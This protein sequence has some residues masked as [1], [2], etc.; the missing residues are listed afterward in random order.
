MLYIESVRL[1]EGPQPRIVVR[2]DWSPGVSTPPTCEI[3]QGEGVSGDGSSGGSSDDWRETES[4]VIIEGGS[5]SQEFVAASGSSASGSSASGSSASGGD[6]EYQARCRI[7][8]ST[9]R[10][11]EATAPLREPS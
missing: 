4:G 11:V 9:G 8:Q 2:G 6:S 3:A 7:S 10:T 5:F 1:N